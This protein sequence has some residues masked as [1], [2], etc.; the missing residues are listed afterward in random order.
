MTANI[1]GTTG[2]D[3]VQ[4]NA[5]VS[6]TGGFTFPSGTTAERPGSPTT[7]VIRYNTDESTFETYDGTTWVKVDTQG[8]PYSV[9]YLVVAGGGGGG[10]AYGGGGGGAGGYLTS[11]VSL[12]PATA[13]T[14][15]VGAGATGGTYGGTHPKNGSNSSVSGT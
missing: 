10:A 15:T 9:E 1:D 13:Y 12:I 11:T 3:K 5:T 4:D 8:Y 7:G 6:G 2:I 14:I